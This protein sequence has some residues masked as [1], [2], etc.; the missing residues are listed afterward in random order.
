MFTSQNLLS[1]LLFTKKNFLSTGIKRSY[2]FTI[3]SPSFTSGLQLLFCMQKIQ[4]LDLKRPA[5]FLPLFFL[6]PCLSSSSFP[7]FKLL[8]LIRIPNYSSKYCY[9]EYLTC[10]VPTFVLN[11]SVKNKH[12]QFGNKLTWTRLNKEFMKKSANICR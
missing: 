12:G 6:F 11:Y 10:T 4:E 8:S 9:N 1:H 2:T 3:A 5:F 7:F